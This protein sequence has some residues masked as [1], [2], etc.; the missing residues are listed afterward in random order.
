MIDKIVILRRRYKSVHMKDEIRFNEIYG[1]DI[2]DMEK[3]N[4]KRI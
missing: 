4:G 2:L 1:I 3:K